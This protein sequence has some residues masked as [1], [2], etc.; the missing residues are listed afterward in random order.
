MAYLSGYS[1]YKV[2]T[3]TGGAD[4]AQTDFQ[5]KIVVSKESAMQG[6]FADLRFTQADGTTLVDAW[7]ELIV[8]DT[9]AT[10]WVEFPTTPANTVEQTYYMYYGNVGVASDWDGAATFPSLFSDFDNLTGWTTRSGSPSVSGGELTLNT[11]SISRAVTFPSNYCV[12][13]RA[14]YNTANNTA[15]FVLLDD[16][17]NVNNNSGPYVGWRVGDIMNYDGS[18]HDGGNYTTGVYDIVEMRNVDDASHTFDL[19]VDDV[20]GVSGAGYRN[21]LNM[22]TVG[23]FESVNA[24][25]TVDWILVRKYAANPPTYAFGAEQSVPIDGNPYWYYNLL[26]RRN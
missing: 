11:A 2:L 13:T 25:F 7:A 16:T 4:G 15:R 1:K 6:A 9:S 24:G 8:T 19:M 14:K 3:L 23:Y 26:K 10:V 22:T 12:R 20:L 5:L 18:W 21:N 17:W